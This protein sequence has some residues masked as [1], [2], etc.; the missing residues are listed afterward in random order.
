MTDLELLPRS[1]PTRTVEA[2]W[3]IAV[4]SPLH[5][6]HTGGIGVEGDPDY[7][8]PRIFM[9]AFLDG[10][11]IPLDP[12]QIHIYH[13]T[14]GRRAVGT[15]GIDNRDLDVVVEYFFPRNAGGALK[16]GD[17]HLVDWMESLAN[18]VIRG[19]TPQRP[20]GILADPD[21]PATT[22]QF[23]MITTGIDEVIY[24]P[25]TVKPDALAAYMT[26]TFTT[27]ENAEGRRPY[28]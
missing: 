19:A 25:I 4:A 14:A 21:Y 13:P 10:G 3:E 26:F 5:L 11:D 9:G 27:K 12:P 7:R 20:A 17:N 18:R 6:A 24:H 2:V 16:R 23:P 8:S 15:S 22:T 28:E 1:I